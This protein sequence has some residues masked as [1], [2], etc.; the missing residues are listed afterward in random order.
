[1][2]AT[3]VTTVDL[4]LGWSGN[5][6]N[7]AIYRQGLCTRGGYQ[8]AVFYT[9]ARELVVV[10]RRLGGGEMKRK[11]VAVVDMLTDAHLTASIGVDSGGHVHLSYYHHNTPLNYRRMQKPHDLESFGE[12]EPMTGCFE[13][14]VCY[15]FFLHPAEKGEAFYFLYRNGVSGNGEIRL[16]RYDTTTRI[17][18]DDEQA[19]LSG[20]LHHPW[21]SNP[22]LQTPVMRGGDSIHL[23]T[24]W[25][26]HA[27]GEKH[28][29]NNI[30]L[31]YLHSCDGGRSWHTSR[32]QPLRRPV[33]QVNGETAVAI[34]PGSN[35]MNQSGAAIDR[36]G[37]PL[38][39]YYADDVHGVPQYYVTR[40]REGGWQT[41]MLSARKEPFA[42]EGGGTLQLPISRPE[43]VVL[44]D[45]RPL[46]LYRADTTKHC[47]VGM[48]LNEATLKPEEEFVLTDPVG[49]A[50]PVID[51]ARWETEGVLTIFVQCNEQPMNEGTP[52]D[53][54]M[55]V[56]LKDWKFE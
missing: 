52:K 44:P 15:P 35:L 2:K 9:Q 26:T 1:M 45:N 55:P 28:R 7:T 37:M 38:T 34:P 16:K 18:H 48:A 17:W 6:L 3:C 23:F 27:L 29:V 4:G 21:N 53:A 10:Q 49:F 19:I 30:N 41:V 14:R 43:V 33:T 31:D 22:Y 32:A 46:V 36:K 54:S 39:V 56:T 47:I 42:L 51:R 12:P 50:E 13:A 11:V 8:Y 5:T 20:M 25:R 40:L 24:T